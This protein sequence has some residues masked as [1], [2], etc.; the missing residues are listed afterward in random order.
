[1]PTLLS[2]PRRCVVMV[3]VLLGL[4]VCLGQAAE[5]FPPARMAVYFSPSGG[6]T[7]AVVRELNAAT[8]QVLMQAYSFTSVPIA[9]ALVDA[10]KRGVTVLAILDK[11][12]KTEKYSAATFLVNAGI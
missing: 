6:A 4:I 7:D 8:T 10:H 12:Q 11:S 3:I 5:P 9:K 2:A 1:M